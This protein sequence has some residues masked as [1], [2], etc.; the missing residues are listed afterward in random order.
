[1]FEMLYIFIQKYIYIYLERKTQ[2]E[3]DRQIDRQI[4]IDIDIYGNS[5]S[6]E[7]FGEK[8]GGEAHDQIISRQRKEDAFYNIL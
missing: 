7:N 2:I 5:F 1:M 4:D 8:I 6:E 3:I